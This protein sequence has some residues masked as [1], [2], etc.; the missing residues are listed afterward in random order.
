MFQGDV[1]MTPST[2]APC[3]WPPSYPAPMPCPTCGRCPTCGHTKPV[4]HFPSPDWTWR[5]PTFTC[6][7]PVVD[8]TTR[9]W[10]GHT[11]N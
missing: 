9:N 2:T 11:S 1:V 3:V 10:V 8:T 6:E 4:W 5:G 7:A